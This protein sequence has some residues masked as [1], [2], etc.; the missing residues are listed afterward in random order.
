MASDFEMPHDTLMV[1][2]MSP[3]TC[4]LCLQSIQWSSA[5]WYAGIT[6]TLIEMNRTL[7]MQQIIG[8]DQTLGG[9][10]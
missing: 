8:S 2:P 3:N 10:P 9:T 1:S 6:P 4:Y 7:P 5:R